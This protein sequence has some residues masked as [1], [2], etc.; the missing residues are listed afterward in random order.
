MNEIKNIYRRISRIIF[1]KTHRI[2]FECKECG[3][4]GRID[5]IPGKE[6]VMGTYCP[7]C[8]DQT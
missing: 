8:S 4:S 6:L 2:N 1:W 7:C 3:W 5:S